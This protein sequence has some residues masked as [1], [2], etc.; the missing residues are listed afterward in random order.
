MIV[1]L[2]CVCR[3]RDKDTVEIAEHSDGAMKVYGS[4]REAERARRELAVSGDADRDN[5]WTVET[6]WFLHK[7][8]S[9][10][11]AIVQRAR[12]IRSELAE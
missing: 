7:G 4:E 5:P 3:N 11:P 12:Q 10:I 9:D 8:Y 1:E 6:I 2:F